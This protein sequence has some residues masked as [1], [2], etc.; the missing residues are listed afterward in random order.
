[1]KF[2]KINEEIERVDNYGGFLLIRTLKPSD[3]ILSVSDE[4]LIENIILSKYHHWRGEE[5]PNGLTV[6]MSSSDN[7]GKSKSWT[8]TNHKF[9][10]FFDNSKIR[11][12]HY[13][14]ITF[15]EFYTQLTSA[16]ERETENDNTFIQLSKNV[17]NKKLRRSSTFYVLDL[18]QEKNKDLVAEWQVYDFFYAFISVDKENNCIDLIEFGLD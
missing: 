12:G 18:D 7:Y 11:A 5:E 4:Q 15:D 13:K 1:M 2:E 10:G 16:M 14:K 6:G 17:I 9:Y 8:L 3:K